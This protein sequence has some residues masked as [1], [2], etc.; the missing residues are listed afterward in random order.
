[1]SYQATRS[2]V[3]DHQSERRQRACDSDGRAQQANAADDDEPTDDTVSGALDRLRA[4]A[5][6]HERHDQE[7]ERCH[8]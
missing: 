3:R 8:G 7:T 2:G 6:E 1:M 4:A 5:I